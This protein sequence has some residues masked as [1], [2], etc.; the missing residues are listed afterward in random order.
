MQLCRD[1]GLPPGEDTGPYR[2]DRFGEEG[3]QRWPHLP[4]APPTV[5]E[6]RPFSQE[7]PLGASRARL[8][9]PAPAAV[10]EGLLW[11][12]NCICFPTQGPLTLTQALDCCTATTLSKLLSLSCAALCP[13]LFP[14]LSLSPPSLPPFLPQQP[15]RHNNKNT[16]RRFTALSC[17]LPQRREYCECVDVCVHVC[18]CV[19]AHTCVCMNVRQR[20][21][22]AGGRAVGPV[23]EGFGSWGSLGRQALHL[24]WDVAS[25]CYF[26]GLPDTYLS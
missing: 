4:L 3:W 8:P 12:L 10:G 1:P 5:S 23:Q 14:K 15:G 7:P 19:C 22:W 26:P 16:K 6:A 21:S 9:L 2:R 25:S 11:G 24:T 17:F 20:G 18:L 13:F